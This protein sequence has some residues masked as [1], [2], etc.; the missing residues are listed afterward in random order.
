[1]ANLP[2]LYREADFIRAKLAGTA[3]AS[4]VRTAPILPADRGRGRPQ[5]QYRE[6]CQPAH[7]YF[8]EMVFCEAGTPGAVAAD[9]AEKRINANTIVMPTKAP[10]RVRHHFTQV[11]LFPSSS[12]R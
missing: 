12:R 3:L 4:T 8:S 10:V 9:A 11:Y 7:P 1:M 5:P 6:F 2:R